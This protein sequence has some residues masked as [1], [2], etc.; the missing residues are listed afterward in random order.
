MGEVIK[1]A[2]VRRP[3]PIDGSETVLAADTI[4]TAIGE[5][6]EMVIAPAVPPLPPSVRLTVM[7]VPSNGA[8]RVCSIFIAS[9][10]SSFWP[11][12]TC[13]PD[14]TG[15]RTTM[16]GIVAPI[17]AGSSGS[18]LARAAW[19]DPFPARSGESG[20]LDVRGRP[21]RASLRKAMSGGAR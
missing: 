13:S 8:V 10:V 2:L 20:L 15:T 18:A 19:A 7:I 4:L 9:S 21:V 1:H 16:P 12:V 11:L 3:E 6:I 5:E 14:F 17:S